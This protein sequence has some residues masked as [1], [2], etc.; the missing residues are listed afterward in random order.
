MTSARPDRLYF[1]SRS[2]DVPPG[3]G[4]HEI[5]SGDYSSLGRIPNW[6][7]KLS[8]F[9]VSP[10]SFGGFQW[11]TVEHM[12]QAYKIQISNPE[13]AYQFTLNSNSSLSRGTGLEAQKQRKCAILN[14]TQLHQWNLI[15]SDVMLGGLRGK[16]STHS[17]LADILLVT[18]PGTERVFDPTIPAELWHGASRQA[19][20]RQFLLEQ[21]R[22]ELRNGRTSNI[23]FISFI[24]K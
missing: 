10:F 2:K 22:T 24:R 9:W 11:N 20:T 3:L 18:G 21:V 13:L 15:K 8:N 5:I 12:F 16:F 4:V 6:R 23:E 17:D 14:P 19:P 1:M 7:Q